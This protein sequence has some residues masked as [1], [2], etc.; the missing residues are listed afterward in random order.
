M[1]LESNP[2]ARQRSP[3][4]TVLILVI[5]FTLSRLAF[6]LMGV[7]YDSS[8]FDWGFQCLDIHVLQDRLL[9]ALLN[10]H[11]QPPGFN[12]FL[13]VV[14]KVFPNSPSPC[15][16]VLYMLLGFTLYCALYCFLRLSQFARSP[17]I[18]VAFVYIISPSS[19][20]YENWLFYTYPVA[21]L[22]ALCA[23][24][25]CCF[26]NTTQTVYAAVFLLLCASVC[27]TRSA[28]HL[29][30]LLACVP[31]VLIPRGI[32]CR[33]VALCA[34]V[35]ICLVT[36]LYVKNLA[37]FGFFGSSSWLGMNLFKTASA[38]VERDYIENWVRSGDISSIASIPPFSPL[39]E[40]PDYIAALSQHRYPCPLPPELAAPT[41][42]NGE[43]N[44][45][46][47]A[48]ISISHEY[49]SAALHLIRKKPL[50]FAR[51]VIGS[52]Q[53]YTRPSWDYKPLRTNTAALSQYIAILSALRDQVFVEGDSFKRHFSKILTSGIRYP[54]TSLLVFPLILLVASLRSVVF[55]YR[56][57]RYGNTSGLVF[58]FMTMTVLYVAILDN[59][60][61]YGENNRFR[62]ETDPLIFLLVA[63][64][65]RDLCRNIARLRRRPN[66]NK[67]MDTYVSPGAY[68]G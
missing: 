45:N 67:S 58:I 60:V 62:V 42:S 43:P 27:L 51:T 68:A 28:F 21:A 37:M 10:L 46:H 25:L 29:L 32:R 6:W 48:Y 47:E 23:V 1:K 59:L 63:V 11:S 9:P 41:K 49:Q 19:I 24:A 52:W 7:R 33:R 57:V 39:S 12:L 44:Y 66:A 56:I 30:F 38:H 17:A 50:L 18:L 53:F 36:T 14:L 61:E 40:Y 26:H 5:S 20:L 2:S 3:L 54:L 13:G 31:F 55:L 35:A 22:L 15:F 16:Q 4:A 65:C 8:V 64:M 34:V